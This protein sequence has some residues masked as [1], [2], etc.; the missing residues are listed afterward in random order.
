MALLQ[1]S[2]SANS[3]AETSSRRTPCCCRNPRSSRR[4]ALTELRS[5]GREVRRVAQTQ[6]PVFPVRSPL[7]AGESSLG[8]GL[9]EGSSGGNSWRRTVIRFL[10]FRK[11]EA[12]VAVQKSV[13]WEE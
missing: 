5:Q 1:A 11:C 9:A 13:G 3:H 7:T 6:G 4:A 8:G 2:A 10:R 12:V